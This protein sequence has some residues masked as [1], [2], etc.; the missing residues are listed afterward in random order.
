MSGFPGPWMPPE[1]AIPEPGALALALKDLAARAD[2]A[3]QQ[4]K[5]VQI[6]PA[7]ARR[8]VSWLREGR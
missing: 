8:L 7:F 5:A 3:E 4:G 1:P 2:V 6:S